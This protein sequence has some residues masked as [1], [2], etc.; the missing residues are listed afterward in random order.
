[1]KFELLELLELESAEFYKCLAAW[2]GSSHV[3]AGGPCGQ[4]VGTLQSDAS[5]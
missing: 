1:M 2:L 5:R 4:D 3:V